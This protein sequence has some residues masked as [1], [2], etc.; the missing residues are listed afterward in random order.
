MLR[1][2]PRFRPAANGASPAANSASPG[3]NSDSP[4]GNGDSTARSASARQRP[5]APPAET[6]PPPP[7]AAA[8][9]SSR[10]SSSGPPRAADRR[11]C[12][13]AP[14]VRRIGDLNLLLPP[15]LAAASPLAACLGSLQQQW[16]QEGHQAALWQA[17]PAIAGPQLAPHCHPL[18][19]QARLLTVGAPPGPWLQAL[20]YNRLQLLGALRAAGFSVRD[21]RFRQYHATPLPAPG[22][23]VEAE[24]WARHPSRVDVHGLADCPGCA[25]PAPAGEMAHWGHCGFC[26]RQ[27]LADLL[28]PPAAG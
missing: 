21:L 7:P 1:R 19:L 16:R 20:Q 26:H 15:G 24:V 2:P 28:P 4:G 18:S 25:R 8:G 13:A 9:R 11:A 3:G 12:A 6:A 23:V 22:S 17:W 27:R 14:E 10:R 5:A